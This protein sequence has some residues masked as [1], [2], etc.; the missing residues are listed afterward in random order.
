MPIALVFLLLG[1]ATPLMAQNLEDRTSAAPARNGNVAVQEE[2]D[3]ARQAG[4]VEAYDLFLARH[5]DHPLA[6]RARRELERLKR[7]QE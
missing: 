2:L 4:T 7:K 3:A 5:P 6:E 1:V